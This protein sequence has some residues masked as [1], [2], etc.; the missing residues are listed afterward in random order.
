VCIYV[1][2]NFKYVKIDI[3]EYCEDKDFEACAIKL[4]VDSKRFCIITLYRAPTGNI[5]VFIT[6]LDII[7]RMWR[8]KHKLSS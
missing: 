2:K 1:Q 6:K 3:N 8:Y 5:D 7:L 4:N